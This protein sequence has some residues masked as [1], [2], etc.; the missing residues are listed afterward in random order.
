MAHD[1]TPSIPGKAADDDLIVTRE[2]LSDKKAPTPRANI[3]WEQGMTLR[4]KTLRGLAISLLVALTLFLLLGGPATTLSAI[5]QAG[6]A[7]N[8][9][10]HPLKPQPM[11]AESGYSFIKSPPGAYN[12][13]EMSIAPATA[14]ASA[15]WACWTSP[16]L[17]SG[18]Q[19]AWTA[20]AY[21]TA[22]GGSHWSALAL[23]S[24][25]AQN[26]TVIA[27]GER[28][29][30][31]LFILTS[32]ATADGACLAPDLYLTS[33][34]GVTWTQVAWPNGPTNAAC[35]FNA[36]LRGGALY[37]W[38]H[39]PL[40]LGTTRKAPPIGRLIVSR[41]AGQLWS[42][43]DYGLNDATGLDIVGFRPG[44]HILAT[45]AD[46]RSSGGASLLMASDNYGASWRDLGQL[47][48]VFPQV[49]VS[50]DSSVTDHGGW[51][52]LYALAQAQVNGLPA[53]PRQFLLASAYLGGGW[54]SIP[55][56]PLPGSS[57]ANPQASDPRIIGL[58]PA[59]S[60]EVERGVIQAANAQ[61]SPSR[62]LWIWSPALRTW[63]LDP[64]P[65]P[66]N[67]ELQG[68]SWR[69]GDQIFWLTTL[70]LGVPPKLQIYTKVF[71][72]KITQRIQ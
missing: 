2:S 70:K 16:F 28:A 42:L 66:G 41:D 36:A 38:S 31:A 59:G 64:Q 50:S 43:A 60:L 35:Q 33:D 67:V 5:R 4:Q 14:Q 15:A 12:L 72:A 18:T 34:T 63:L 32:G 61:L 25:K 62:R 56:P 39:D 8:A 55:L 6:D 22:S 69:A 9:R 52:R 37:L 48:G 54:A 47:P 29:N 13:P 1:D 44:G 71:H 27:D 46:A 11:L 17:P 58:G 30:S 10:L 51:G 24:A 68:A 23:P 20:H 49:Y 65:V 3:T 26:C 19:G 7:L 45:I 57:A 40:M 53:S 21:Y